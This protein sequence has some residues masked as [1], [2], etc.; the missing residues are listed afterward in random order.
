MNRITIIALAL[1]C[2]LS[3]A[4]QGQFVESNPEFQPKTN[5]R[6]DKT[7]LLYPDGQAAGHGIIENGVEITFG[8]RENNGLTGEET[9]TKTGSRRNVGDQARMDFY[10]APHPNGQMV[11]M[12]PGGGYEHLSSFNEGA[13]GS[14]WMTDRG[15]SVCMLK[16]RMPN[17]HPTV[18][19]DDV[20]NAFRYCRHHAKEWGITQIGV[21]GGSAG[22]HLAS[23][24][25]V[26]Y[27]DEITRPDFAVLLYPRITLR[28]GEFCDTKVNLVGKDDQW[29]E[30][31]AEHEAL[32]EEYSP[33]TKVNSNTPPTFIVL[34]AN[35]LSV[36]GTNMIPY[37][38]RLIECGVSTE[39]H[40]FPEGGHGWGYSS[41]QFKG[42][43]KDK[44]AHY[45]PDFERLL[46]RW[47]TDRRNDGKEVA[48]VQNYGTA[49]NIPYSQATDE[50]S[51]SRCKLD[52]YY[53]LGV[54]DAP[55]LVWFHGGGLTGGNRYVPAELKNSGMII[56]SVDYRL[57][58]KVG[59]TDCIDDAAAA[60]AWAFEHAEEYGGS[61]SRIFVSGHSAGGYLTSMVG[62]DRKYLNKYGIEANEIAGLIPLSGQ[63]I[64]HFAQRNLSG[65][66]AL[67][68]TVDETAPLY[69]VRSDASP[70]LIISG[71]RN[72]E[73]NGRY[74]EQAYFWRMMNLTGH[75]DCQI[76]EMQGYDHGSMPH[77]AF[78]IIKRF[79]AER[80]K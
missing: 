80:C 5:L 13:Y 38:S 4:A 2:S 9:N 41:E 30:R 25:S 55:V 70:M 47:L 51:R 42:V 67:Q 65:I 15:I 24:A 40:V 34:S 28:R 57:M 3:M 75:R 76:L 20:H 23:L 68:A 43:G 16:Y 12:T 27:D 46:E 10:F 53:P 36:P 48:P 37:Y 50:Y 11:I 60:V 7:V 31:V 1:T 73:M 35:D 8:P 21:T 61:R 79:I 72:L 64:T 32:L 33:D 14:K 29:N 56:V 58:P 22:G 49:N 59:I 71:D 62:L 45:R 54:K 39:L 63:A 78:P 19:I 6:P 69:H 18:P 26:M 44:F 66:G 77:P 74:E 17:G 52:V